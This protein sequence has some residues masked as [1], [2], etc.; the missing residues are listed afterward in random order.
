MHMISGSTPF[1]IKVL[2]C[3]V[4]KEERL[5]R[6]LDNN[7]VKGLKNRM[8]CDPAAPGIPPLALHC[9][10]VEK[11]EDFLI[12]LVNQYQYEVLGGTHTIAA[13]KELLEEMPGTYSSLDTY[14]VC[15]YANS[16]H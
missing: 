6:K 1:E 8:R 9:K 4:P 16:V 3:E 10:D 12:H 13:R 11:K 15:T 7:F 5:L 14:I 2:S